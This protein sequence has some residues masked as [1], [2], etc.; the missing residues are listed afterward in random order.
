MFAAVWR[1]AAL[2]TRPSFFWLCLAYI[3]GPGV[4]E[5][6]AAAARKPV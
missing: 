6:A 5:T 2:L 1:A 3:A 4:V